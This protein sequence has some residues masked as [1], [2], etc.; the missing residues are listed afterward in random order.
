[1]APAAPTTSPGFVYSFSPIFVLI[2]LLLPGGPWAPVGH[3]APGAAQRIF[4]RAPIVTVNHQIIL[5]SGRAQSAYGLPPLP[6]HS[7]TPARVLTSAHL[8]T[9]PYTQ[10]SQISCPLLVHLLCLCT[11]QSSSDFFFF[12]QRDILSVSSRR[13]LYVCACALCIF[14][15]GSQ[16]SRHMDNYVPAPLCIAEWIHINDLNLIRAWRHE[17]PSFGMGG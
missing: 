4:T 2:F 14:V 8:L 11:L 5:S 7:L 1:M 9:P 10:V 15:W 13:Q 3:K 17:I 16:S 12:D 6:P